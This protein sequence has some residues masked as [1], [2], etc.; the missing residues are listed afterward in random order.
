MRTTASRT[1]LSLAALGLLVAGC[2]DDSKGTGSSE[3][4]GP[5][6]SESAP[7]TRPRALEVAKAWDGSPAAETWRAG[8]YPLGDPVQ[9]PDGPSTAA[10]TRRRTSAGTSPCAA[11]FPRLPGRTRR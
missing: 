1:A 11:T 8:Y 5:G 6:A 4:T 9:L 7:H 10:P 2:G 3:P